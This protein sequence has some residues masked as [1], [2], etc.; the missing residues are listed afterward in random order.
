MYP[1]GWFVSLAS[2]VWCWNSCWGTV[3]ISCL[4]PCIIFF[5]V[6]HAVLSTRWCIQIKRMCFCLRGAE[7]HFSQSPL[8][9]NSSGLW[10]TCPGLLLWVAPGEPMSHFHTPSSSPIFNDLPMVIF[11]KR[12]FFIGLNKFPIS[13]TLDIFKLDRGDWM[14]NQ[15]WPSKMQI[16]LWD[17]VFIYLL[18]VSILNV[19]HCVNHKWLS[20]KL[21]TAV[22][23]IFSLHAAK[24][25]FLT[26]ICIQ[27]QALRHFFLFVCFITSLVVTS[28]V[29]ERKSDP[30]VFM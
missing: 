2:Q 25:D 18:Y 15:K 30:T 17:N 22:R 7:F 11:T 12:L 23:M 24:M 20:S 28:L 16:N 21:F 5:Q 13:L 9:L 26:F 6:E 27:P 29:C 19:W 3:Q 10:S 8:W 4:C 1:T 14:P